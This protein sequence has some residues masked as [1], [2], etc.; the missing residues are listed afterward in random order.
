MTQD[1]VLVVGGAGYI[2]SHMV[3]TLVAH[4]IPV[5]V[6]DDLSSGHA[7]TVPAQI[8]F[9]QG[10]LANRDMLSSIFKQHHITAVMHFAAFIEVSESVKDPAR[11]YHNNVVKT[12]ALLDCMRE[13]S[14]RYFIFSSTAAVYGEPQTAIINEQHPTL[15]INPYGASKLMVEQVC[16]DYTRAYDFHYVALR[17]F[18]AAGAHPDGHLAERHDPETHLIPIL[19]QV[20]QGLRPHCYLYGDDYP[21]PDGSCV[22]DFIHVM[23]L[24]SAHVAA[25][26]YLFN[27]GQ[28]IAFNVGTSQ[29]LSVKHVIERVSAITGVPLNVKTAARRAGDP[30]QLVADSTRIQSVCGWSPRYSNI[31]TII[32]DA[33]RVCDKVQA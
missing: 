24:C 16:R 7:D 26:S 13:H 32:A 23:D 3:A 19:L 5:V 28:S 27:G 6:L 20:A 4:S 9:Y 22:R 1:T 2:G 8:T 29:G 30:S 15:P 10:D 33:W 21:T 14:I 11:Y 18:N 31:D 25:L 12:V 17:Y